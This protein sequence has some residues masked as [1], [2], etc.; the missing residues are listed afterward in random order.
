[1]ASGMSGGRQGAGMQ[2]QRHQGAGLQQ[3]A[4]AH[5]GGG[6]YGQSYAGQDYHEPEVYVPEHQ[7]CV[8]ECPWETPFFSLTE[9]NCQHGTHYELSPAYGEAGYGHGAGGPPVAQ[10]RSLLLGFGDFDDPLIEPPYDSVDTRYNVIYHSGYIVLWV[11]FGIFFASGWLFLCRSWNFFKSGCS[12]CCEQRP[13]AFLCLPSILIGFINIITSIDYLAMA[14][15]NGYY[16]RCFD[17]RWIFWSRYVDWLITTPLLL[18]I[19]LYF[20]NACDDTFIFIFWTDIL[21]ILS[22]L[23]GATIADSYVWFFFAFGILL[24]LPITFYVLSLRNQCVDCEYDYSL[25]FWNFRNIV[26]IFAVGWFFYPWVWVAATATNRLSVNG[27]AIAYF[28]LDV[29][30]KA[31]FGWFII[32][33][34]PICNC[35]DFDDCEGAHGKIRYSLEQAGY[36]VQED[37]YDQYDHN[38]KYDKYDEKYEKEY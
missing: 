14:T 25:F 9:C 34:R 24:F 13:L 20:A 31:L 10:G 22:G 33:M 7:C 27:E 5:G 32:C 16:V 4:R 30:T 2:Q 21:M 35:C 37:K 19:I 15:E 6:G 12:E 26:L 29:I 28:V 38:E 8:T 11:G 17:G 3:M 23:I 1:M 36:S 18:W